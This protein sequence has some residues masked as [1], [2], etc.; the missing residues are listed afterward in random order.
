MKFGSVVSADALVPVGRLVC[1]LIEVVAGGKVEDPEVGRLIGQY[2][3]VGRR[4]TEA[5]E[6]FVLAL[7]IGVVEVFAVDAPK[8]GQTDDK[9]GTNDCKSHI[10][11]ATFGLAELQHIDD[12][13]GS[14]HGDK[15]EAPPCAGS[16]NA[17]VHTDDGSTISL[18]KV[19]RKSHRSQLFKNLHVLSAD[20]VG[21]GRNE[22]KE[23]TAA[24]SG[25]ETDT[26]TDASA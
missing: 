22:G 24:G 10:A 5:L 17:L 12:D 1:R 19:K 7:E 14:S 2:H 21:K 11:V 20:A 13:D 25:E 15:E 18:G 3:L 23:Q 9:E 8:V 4:R 6:T 26:E 16:E